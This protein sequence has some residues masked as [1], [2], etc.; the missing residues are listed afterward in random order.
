M[1]RGIDKRLFFAK[2]R[3]AIRLRLLK[4]GGKSSLIGT[5]GTLGGSGLGPLFCHMGGP[6]LE[7]NPTTLDHDCAE[8]FLQPVLMDGVMLAPF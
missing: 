2:G 8:R 3:A 6:Y 4:Q 1:P 5:K 7:K